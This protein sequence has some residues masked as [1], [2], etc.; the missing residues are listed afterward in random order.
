M[1]SHS[2]KHNRT[3]VR[4]TA[5]LIKAVMEFSKKLAIKSIEIVWSIEEDNG[6]LATAVDVEDT[7]HLT[8][9][10]STFYL[11]ARCSSA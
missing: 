7:N 1:F 5:K 2:T 11:C 3:H 8:C 4:I 9:D 6:Y 10:A